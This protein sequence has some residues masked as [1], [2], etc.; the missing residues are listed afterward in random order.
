MKWLRRNFIKILVILI[1]SLLIAKLLLDAYDVQAVDNMELFLEILKLAVP[2]AMISAGIIG[3]LRDFRFQYLLLALAGGLILWQSYVFDLDRIIQAV[4]VINDRLAAA[5]PM[6]FRDFSYLVQT[7]AIAAVALSFLTLYIYPWNLLILDIAFLFFLWAVDNLPHKEVIMIPFVFMWGFLLVHERMTSRDSLYGEY[8]QMKINRRSRLLQGMVIAAL[9]GAI[10]LG[11]IRDTRGIYYDKLWIRA[12]DYLMQDDFMSGSYF[13]DAFS[14]VRTGYQDASTRLG[15]DV[16]ITNE[17]ALKIRG[18]VPGYLR[19]NTKYRYTGTIWEKNDMLYRTDNSA[20]KLVTEAYKNAPVREMEVVPENVATSSL[21][22]TSY[23]GSVIPTSPGK[24]NRVFYGIQDQTFMV[25]EPLKEAYRVTYYDQAF[26][27]KLAM[28]GI[29]EGVPQDY[30]KYLELPD[31]ITPRTV[32][33]VNSIIKGKTGKAQKL[34]A[35]T[36]YLRE[37]YFYTLRPGRV[38][39]GQDFVDYFLFE[40]KAGY[41]VYYATA[42]TVMLRI[43]G[44]PARYAEGFKVSDEVDQDGDTLIRNSDAHAWTEVLTDPGRDL[45]TIWDATGS[46]RDNT[47]G[48]GQ[49]SNPEP[50]PNQGSTTTPQTRTAA[51]DT[52]PGPTSPQNPTQGP[53]AEQNET[54]SRLWYFLAPAGILALLGAALYLK[55]R[56]TLAM[57]EENSGTDLLNYV[58]NLIEESGIEIKAAETLSE[59]GNRITDPQL[60]QS[61]MEV[62][63]THYET[64][65]GKTYAGK[66]LAQRRQLLEEAYRVYGAEHSRIRTF[67]RRY[68]V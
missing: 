6:F 19:G 36:N 22:V 53:K 7:I 3:M 41:C 13:L 56:R 27:E 2:T 59:I 65:Y 10:S 43:A 61:F 46:V 60:K 66:G 62:V 38:P 4:Q 63:R 25:N 37:N 68:L 42:L 12:N 16:A 34:V 11:L 47:A 24:T 45:W 35:I 30:D 40:V 51:E 32:E 58:V 48:G 1:N 31:T 5:R 18:D 23:P 29:A 54:A 57:L 52:L 49:G 44:I 20:S 21:F 26:V 15:G 28:D 55:K 50:S 67:L 17:L 8:R 39:A 33:L 14:L 64:A 9:I